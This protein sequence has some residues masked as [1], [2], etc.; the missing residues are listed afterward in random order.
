MKKQLP[1]LLFFLLLF[2][3]PG[4][5]QSLVINEVITSNSEVITDEDGSYEDWVE[6]YNGTNA[7][8][9]LNGYG[10]SDNANLHQWVFP[11]KIMAPGEYLLVWCSDKNRVNSNAPLHTNF[12]ISSGGETIR[13]TD[14]AGNPVDVAAAMVVPQN[15]TYGR[16]PNGTGGFKIFAE[17]TPGAA[18]TTTGY[19][20]ILPAPSFSTVSGFY[21][22]PVNLSIFPGSAGSTI[23]YT[24][25][26]SE[27]DEN[28]LSGTTYHYKNQ[29]PEFPEQETGPL[30]TNSYK[31][32]IYTSPLLIEDRNT[33]AND[34]SGIATS[35]WLNVDYL[36]TNPVPKSTVVRAKTIKPGAMPSPTVTANYF[37]SAQGS[38]WFSLPVAA[39]SVDE[40]DMFDYNDGIQVPGVDFDEW[41]DE[42]PE[43]SADFAD[44]NYH[45]SGD[46]WEIKGNFSYYN[47]TQEVINQDIGIRINGN[48]SAMA[49]LKSLRLVARAS[50]GD[51]SMDY[52][53]FGSNYNSYKRLILRNSGNDYYLTLFRDAFIH[54]SVSHLNFE[55]QA[56]Q[57]TITF[58]NGEYWGLLNLRERFDK[59]YFERVFDISE[60]ELDYIENIEVKEGDDVHYNAMLA[61]I[62]NNPLNIT[63]NYN[64]ATTM[65]DP[66][67][68][69]DYQITQIY[70]N[71]QDWPGNNLE[72]FRKRTTAYEP[73]APAGQ[74]GRWR[75][76]LKDT[77]FGL[78]F[79]GTY[80][81]NTL[82]FATE[83]DGPEY[84][85]PAWST[86]LLRKMI[87]N[88]QFKN[89]F[90]NRFADLLNTTFLPSRMTPIYNTLKN[91]IAPE[92]QGHRT[93][94]NYMGNDQNW[95][96]ACAVMSTFIEERPFHQRMHIR[97]K[98]NISTNVTATLN[99]NASTQGFIKINTIDVKSTTPGVAQNPYPWQGIYFH[100]IPV[101]LKAVAADGYRFSHWS[102]DVTGSESEITYLPV[103]DFEAVANFV[104]DDT[105]LALIPVYFWALG[106][107]IANDIPLTS[108]NATFPALS[109]AVLNFESCLTGYPFTSSHTSW[110]KASM[111]R[112]NSPT[113]INY[114]PE[115]N[116]GIAFAA[117]NMRGI[118]IKQPFIANGR[119]NAMVFTLPTTGFKD[120]LFAFAAKDENAA[121]G[122]AIEYSITETPV[123][124]AAATQPMPLI[125]DYK[126]F[127]TDF[128]TIDTAENNPY[129]KVRLRFTGTTATDNG[130]RVTFNNISLKGV[131]IP[132][133]IAAHETL[134]V[135]VYPNPFDDVVYINHQYDEIAYRI[136]SIDG[137]LVQA[138]TVSG[139]NVSLGQLQSGIYMMHLSADNKTTTKKIIKR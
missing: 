87:E 88:E 51:S 77:D 49:P 75:W 118:Q 30:L 18:N 100:N 85:N 126:L 38:S 135:S 109:G 114:M 23:I 54:T 116:N 82:A 60:D 35:Y 139:N 111:E 68:F 61:Y 105:S 4:V 42:N 95:N 125:N 12:K 47:N 127:T 97:G 110:R 40:D 19:S 17:P 89:Y 26:G 2:S 13:L 113:E 107:N 90:I 70:I 56:Y 10:L 6:L 65:L 24:L 128:K 83:D 71:N 62:E 134:S 8:I 55:T 93:R 120:L 29:Y 21:T 14:N 119:E 43:A 130:D 78:G 121:D 58:I 132:A 33:A 39:I 59:H 124:I 31:S 101:T 22:Q 63:G 115:A 25:D 123:W 9:N 1:V 57:P 5:C 20:E 64:H 36:Q 80:E 37:I 133:G 66:E 96:D 41:R 81:T 16:S 76:V 112:R 48:F 84:P 122:I 99:V 11:A 103:E 106:N 32:T 102:G 53:F 104:P 94:W 129:F 72:Y 74:D 108:I 86:F 73:G 79:T 50:Y 131:P 52:N 44:A 137:K 138:G 15:Y 3:I 67:N 28:N 98:F 46:D 45:R 34:I 136:F 27:P 69:A 92:M 7:N 117:S 91:R